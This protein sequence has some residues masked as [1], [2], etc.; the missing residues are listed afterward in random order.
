MN[1]HGAAV[2]AAVLVVAVSAAGCGGSRA[3]VMF[4]SG[5]PWHVAK[6][7]DAI[8]RLWAAGSVPLCTRDDSS[9]T[10]TRISPVTIH[11]QIHLDRI[12]VRKVHEYDGVS[13]YNPVTTVIGTYRGVPP[14]SHDPNGY[15]VRSDCRFR[16]L[17][18]PFY[19]V[20]VV[21]ARTGVKGGWIHG[22]RVD[23]RSGDSSGSYVIPF[24]FALC[25]PRPTGGYCS[26]RG[27]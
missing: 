6:H 1:R 20:V 17:A 24:T 4:A 25:G 16:H 19:E 22:M 8:G 11:G 26:L 21:A 18:D 10:L 15:V 23:Y 2:L 7:A 3:D 12:A 27:S 13:K 9:A 14:G 5:V